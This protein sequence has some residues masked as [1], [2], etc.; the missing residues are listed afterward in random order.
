MSPDDDKRTA[1]AFGDL[2]DSVH[3]GH[4]V[5]PTGGGPVQCPKSSASAVLRFAVA[6]RGGVSLAVWIGGAFVE[7]DRVRRNEDAFTNKLL[8]ITRFRAV[9]V[10]IL[11]GASA[12][13]LNAA[14]GG[15]AM[16]HGKEPCLRDTWIETADIDR[17]LKWEPKSK[18]D[19]EPKKR[20]S[21]LNG[22][23][24]LREIRKQLNDSTGAHTDKDPVRPVQLFLAATVL[25]GVPVSDAS[26]PHFVD[27]RHE[28][29]FHFRHLAHDG[30]FSD[31]VSAEAA[32]LLAQAARATASFP[33]AFE[34]QRVPLKNFEG[35][36]NIPQTEAVPDEVDLYDGGVVDN[37]PVARAIRAAAT[38]PAME[39]V[40]RWVLFLH[41]SP[42]ILRRKSSEDK[43]VGQGRDDPGRPPKVPQVVADVLASKVTETLLDDLDV[44]RLH[45][46][47]AVAQAVQR[48]SLCQQA[49]STD[50]GTDPVDK[51]LASVDAYWLYALLENPSAML[52]WNPVGKGWPSSP[53]G[54]CT[55]DQRFHERIALM[56]HLEARS[57]TARPF[58]RVA[59]IAHLTIDWIRWAE[60]GGTHEAI[61]DF[62]DARR[63]TYDV[64][65]TAEL[66]EAALCRAFIDAAPGARIRELERNLTRTEGSLALRA[67]I[68]QVGCQGRERDMPF[69]D[70]L[71]G[72]PKET[73][74]ALAQGT[75]PKG[76]KLVGRAGASALLLCRLAEVGH[77]IRE[78]A[79]YTLGGRDP[80]VWTLLTQPPNKDRLWVERGLLVIDA[81]CAGLHR[82]RLVG[83]PRSL[84]YLR[85][86]GA[87]PTPLAD[88]GFAPGRLPKL[89]SLTVE[90]DL[91]DPKTKLAG[92]RLGNFSAFLSRRFRANDW[93]WGR[94]DAAAGLVEV[95]LAPDHLSRNEVGLVQRVGDVVRAPFPERGN[96]DPALAA[97]AETV[98]LDLWAAYEADVCKELIGGKDLATVRRL[99]TTRW[100]LELFVEEVGRVLGAPLDAGV[101]QAV[102]SISMPASTDEA[103][104]N[105]AKVMERYDDLP[106]HAGD[107]WGPR[108]STAL[109]VRAA[110]HA[111]R[112]IA[113]RAAILQYLLAAPLMA[114]ANAVLL[115]GAFLVSS[116]LLI[117]V[118]LVPRLVTAAKWSVVV[119]TAVALFFFWLKCVVPGPRSR[120]RTVP[121]A[122]FAACATAFGVATWFVEGTTP[123]AAPRHLEANSPLAVL[124]AGGWDLWRSVLTVAAATAL[125]TALLWLWA[126]WWWVVGLA[127]VSGATLGWWT[128]VGS[129]EPPDEG[130]S[131]LWSVH[132]N[133]GS[134]WVGVFLLVLLATFVTVRWRPED[135]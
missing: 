101:R 67:I 34:P 59:R 43:G 111:A 97:S 123:F 74:T 76:A 44:L 121:P 96:V 50:N 30:A 103:Y 117:N 62:S 54:G 81:A 40:R 98:C 87:Q 17:L 13:G 124:D 10:D 105:L 16:A 115:R 66:V 14:L 37:I 1:L 7:I 41:P 86:S 78:A 9:E 133:V 32:S 33:G 64:L 134:M 61:P 125:A 48:Y 57:T 26:D 51:R 120:W 36:L 82:G 80:S 15:L 73:L 2:I 108:R 112:A 71:C 3:G 126:K 56:T 49:L 91:V 4:G 23:Y 109:G 5:P 27:Q 39:S 79:R 90:G 132:G 19:P 130:A 118:V 28:A 47:E 113:P 116:A 69:I 77:E 68:D 85:V 128:I 114:A 72:G 21:I 60:H 99:I 22:K 38:A 110:E 53:L 122:L 8:G 18:E 119:L 75:L 65:L 102:P 63:V 106:R 129:W 29:Y 24:F 92:D 11:T 42:T 104:E 83:A 131:F 20:R 84:N 31:L 55:D 45:N 127:V 135:R 6:M 107:L 46:R 93:M 94:M 35:R 25:G 12:G 89:R 58:A 95:L 52:P 100:Q 70:R 88:V